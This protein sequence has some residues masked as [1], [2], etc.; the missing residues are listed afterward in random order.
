MTV[1]LTPSYELTTENASSSYGQPVLVKRATG[2]AFGPGDILE[3]FP[4]WGLMPAAR[5]VARMAKTASLDDE[6]QAL[7]AKFTDHVVVTS[8]SVT[9]GG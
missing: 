8:D 5:A 6:E 9:C 4:S 2:E 3:P 1:T 7:V